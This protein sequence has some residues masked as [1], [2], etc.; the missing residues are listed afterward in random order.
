MVV[1]SI[2]LAFLFLLSIFVGSAA[3]T[4]GVGPASKHMVEGGWMIKSSADVKNPTAVISTSADFMLEGWYPSEKPGTVMAVLTEN[5]V[6]PD[7]FYAK[8]LSDVPGTWP[9]PLDVSAMP[10]PPG[11]PFRDPWWYRTEFEVPDSYKGKRV[12]LHFD[13]INYAADIWVN[14]DKVAD[15]SEVRGTYRTFEFDMT[16]SVNLGG[17]NVLA[18]KVH[19]PGHRDLAI[20]WVDWNPA[21]PDR[22]MGLWREVYLTSS[23]PVKVR[24]PHVVTDLESRDLAR[25]TVMAEVYNASSKDVTGTV[26]AVAAG[27]KM[28]REVTVGAGRWQRVAFTPDDVPGLAI[29][30]PELWWPHT[31]GPQNLHDLKVTFRTAGNISDSQKVR[32]G[33][34]EV[35]SELLDDDTLVF[36]INGERVL[37]RGAGWTPDMFFRQPPERLRAELRYVKDMNMNAVRI[38]GKFETPEFFRICDEEGIMVMVGW[39]CCHHW[40]R[41]G[42]WDDEDYFVAEESQRD[43]AM[44]IRHHPSVFAW[45]NGSDNPPPPDV[46]KTYLEVLEEAAWTTPAVSSATE[47]PTPVT[48]PSG[49]KM[50]GPYEWVPPVYWYADDKMGGAWSFNTET[51]PGP[52]V[53]PVESMRKFVPEDRLWP[54]N[55]YWNYHAGRNMFG[56]IDV[57]K[58]AQDRRYGESSGAKEF[59]MKSQAMTYEGQRAMMEAYG[60]NKYTSTGIIQWMLNDAWPSIIW[61]LY[62]YYLLPGGGYFGT[63]KACEPLHVQYAYHDRSVWVVNSYYRRFDD[64]SVTARVFNLDMEEVFSETATVS[65]EKD[66][67]VKVLTVPDSGDYSA[68]YFLDLELVDGTGTVVSDNF[69]WLSTKDDELAWGRTQWYYT[70]TKEYA[71]MTGLDDLPPAKVEV[72]WE[73]KEVGDEVMAILRLENPGDTL[74]FFMRLQLTRGKGGEEILPVFWN[75]NYI[76]LLPGEKATVVGVV[77]KDGLGGELPGLTISG[78]NV[79]EISMAQDLPA[80]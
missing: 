79:E 45:L 50:N 51:S 15:S 26:E 27:V 37:I 40:E 72:D 80:K 67:T 29:K 73:Y 20:T 8:D 68:T 55:S 48:G 58:K 42:K 56:N 74:A 9:K 32:F 24:Y 44:K 34:R 2:I 22:N 76:S 19:P 12:W 25:L 60:W 30:D 54:V 77:S 31:V 62:D 69:Y 23:G 78:W 65:V 49:V 3:K 64:L 53:P 52:A 75:D 11:S 63:R 61:H 41:W 46:E 47:E 28:K 14:G 6:F 39:C 1:R 10:M 5:N 4:A 38:E 13:G 17:K 33:I 70:P 21:P 59:T 66:G 43:Q 36:M 71:D 7:P 57:Y 18:V 35:T 16:E